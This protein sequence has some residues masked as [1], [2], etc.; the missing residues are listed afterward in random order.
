[1]SRTI[2][3]DER[4]RK[5]EGKRRP[6]PARGLRNLRSLLEDEDE[7]VSG[8]YTRPESEHGYDLPE[9]HPSYGPA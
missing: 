9:A 8:F 4:F 6:R 5:S 1:M 2:R 7:V 3:R